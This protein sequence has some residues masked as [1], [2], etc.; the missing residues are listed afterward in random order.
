[1]IIQLFRRNWVLVIL[2]W[3]KIG[4]GGSLCTFVW[5]REGGGGSECVRVAVCIS[6]LPKLELTCIDISCPFFQIKA[7]YLRT[8]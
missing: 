6:E 1:M 3:R 5:L 8:G 7:A 2:N 4:G